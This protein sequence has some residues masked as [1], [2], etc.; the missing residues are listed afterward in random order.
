M[1]NWTTENIAYRGVQRRCQDHNE[2]NHKGIMQ[3]Y[4]DVYEAIEARLVV[5]RNWI[6]SVVGG[7]RGDGR[8][9]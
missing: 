5:W 7:R 9:T 2:W 8:D 6:L 3:E 4:D 1:T